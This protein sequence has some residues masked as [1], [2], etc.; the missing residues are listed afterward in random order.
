[1]SRT[2]EQTVIR[3]IP[4]RTR[5][6]TGT[7]LAALSLLL[8]AGCSSGE[9]VVDKDEVAQQASAALEERVGQAPDDLTCAEDLPAKVGASIRCE[10]TAG[11]QTYGV[12][13]TTTSAEGNNAEFDILVDEEPME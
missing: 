6:V 2:H 10:L 5:V 13:I 12:T 8:A 9:P 7:T 11:G 4:R 3:H 1:M